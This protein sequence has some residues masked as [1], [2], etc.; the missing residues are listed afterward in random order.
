FDTL[1]GVYTGSAVNSLTAVA[2]NDDFGSGTTSQVTFAATAGTT[3]YIAVD[4]KNGVT[5]NVSLHVVLG[6]PAPANDNFAN[7]TALTGSSPTATGTNVSASKETGEPNHAGNA[8]GHSVWWKWTAPSTRTFPT[9][10][11]T[12]NFDTLLGVYTGSAVNSLTAVAS[13]DD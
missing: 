1:L 6:P 7:A 12:N 5:G 8:G 11:S 3:Y 2:S 10:R 13:N 9:R 4:G